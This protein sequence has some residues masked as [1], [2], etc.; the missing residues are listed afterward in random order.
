M[1]HYNIKNGLSSAWYFD[2][3]GENGVY[4]AYLEAE[5]TS[6]RKLIVQNSFD[7]ALFYKKFGGF[8]FSQTIMPVE[9]C[10]FTDDGKIKLVYRSGEEYKE[11]NATLD[12]W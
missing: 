7:S 8:Y 2:V 10:A 11:Q 12:L 3:V 5:L 9:E 4:I 6:D 1:K